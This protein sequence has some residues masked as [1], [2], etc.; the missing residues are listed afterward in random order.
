LRALHLSAPGGEATGHSRWSKQVVCILLLCLNIQLSLPPALL[1]SSSCLSFLHN[2]TVA[3][4]F[5]LFSHCLLNSSCML[6]SRYTSSTITHV[7]VPKIFWHHR[8]GG[9][10]DYYWKQ[11]ISSYNSEI[12]CLQVSHRTIK[13]ASIL[14]S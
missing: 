6:I 10:V 14:N 8:G 4:H 12:E 2:Q 1:P 11:K 9:L 7:I 13:R 3:D 5:Q